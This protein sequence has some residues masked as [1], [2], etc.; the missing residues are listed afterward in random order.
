MV[1]VKLVSGELFMATVLGDTPES[2]IVRDP[3]A[4][5]Q[6]QV[7]AQG[8]VIE[9]TVT[10][11]FCSLTEEREYSFDHSHIL[12]IKPLSERISSYY[13]QLLDE[14]HSSDSPAP[15]VFEPE[16]EEIEVEPTLVIPDKHSIH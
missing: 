15:S 1:V 10:N 11:P 4:V 13:K 6:I 3:V 16:E 9:K 14:I 5:R 7:A 12:F 8:G 2:L